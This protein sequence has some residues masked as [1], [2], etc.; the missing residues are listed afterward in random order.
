MSEPASDELIREIKAGLDGVTPGP[1]LRQSTDRDGTVFIVADNLGGL[2]G[3][4]LPWPTEAEV[5]GSA[6]IE[7]N[8]RHI[9]RCSP[10]NI[11]ALLSRI[12]AEKACAEKAEGDSARLD[13]LQ[14]E[15]WDLRCFSISIADTGDAD[16]GW[17]VV[18]HWQAKPTER[19]VGVGFNED[20]REAIDDAKARK[21]EPYRAYSDDVTD[22]LASA[23]RRYQTAEASNARLA[24]ELAEAKRVREPVIKR[25]FAFLLAFDAEDEPDY[26]ARI[27]SAISNLRS[28]LK[29]YKRATAQPAPPAPA[30]N[31]LTSDC[32]PLG[33]LQPDSET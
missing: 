16:I 31:D 15:C 30:R 17:Q 22:A 33:Y 6:R 25:A 7:A 28:E 5:G 12:E 2:V 24:A 20:I 11:A 13:L 9:A 23:Q 19:V 14:G 29:T 10:D 32:P 1:W 3:A 27:N 4:A 21:G 26:A 8:A 18:G